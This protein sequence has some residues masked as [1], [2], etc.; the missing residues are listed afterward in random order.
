MYTLLT[1]IPI[2]WWI[3]EFEPL[4]ATID[5]IPMSPWLRDAFSCVKCVSFWLTLFVSFDFILACQAAILAYLLTRL[6]AR[7]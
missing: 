3:T 6:I 2:A 1:L 5:R 7:L 4:Q